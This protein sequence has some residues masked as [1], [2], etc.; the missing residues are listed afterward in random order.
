[1]A[2][3]DEVPVHWE[4]AITDEDHAADAEL[5]SEAGDVAPSDAESEAAAPEPVASTSVLDQA[6]P[7]TSKLTT[8]GSGLNSN[9]G[10]HDNL[11][12]DESENSLKKLNKDKVIAHYFKQKSK[13]K[14][15][16]TKANTAAATEKTATATEKT[17]CE[18]L[19]KTI[20]KL[21]TENANNLNRIE[22]Q[23]N[24]YQKLASE[25]GQ[26]KKTLASKEKALMSLVTKLSKTKNIEQPSAAAKSITPNVLVITD[27]YTSDLTCKLKKFNEATT[28]EFMVMDSFDMMTRSLNV[29]DFLKQMHSYDACIITCGL[30]DILENTSK[31]A[32]CEVFEK[33]DQTVKVLDALEIDIYIPHLV[34]VND[35]DKKLADVTIYNLQ[36]DIKQSSMPATIIATSSLLETF[37]TSLRLQDDGYTLREKPMEDVA[38]LIIDSVKPVKKV[39]GDIKD[40][41]KKPNQSEPVSDK[42]QPIRQRKSAHGQ[43]PKI[44]RKEDDEDHG[45]IQDFLK[46]DNSLNGL[47]IGRG[48]CNVKKIRKDTGAYV[49]MTDI[50]VN[51]IKTHGALIKGHSLESVA[52]AMD[53]VKSTI[54]R[55]ASEG[56][57]QS[58]RSH[59]ETDLPRIKRINN[60]H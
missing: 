30:R 53:M 46:L 36:L 32:S 41:E 4:Q 42:N 24:S 25:H 21:Q 6:Q 10:T 45:N 38:K 18:N 16:L 5:N 59:D 47:I 13:W 35:D 57:Q 54:K 17:R 31:Y 23:R 60:N 50:D 12:A 55:D 26:L 8:S 37:P 27:K 34:P 11:L 43:I 22:E 56:N 28:W 58:K 39:K 40:F 52:A 29:T 51:G 33:L 2:S 15:A 9:G 3:D 19:E 44:P 20:T 7:D 14:A 48:G 49:T 1:M